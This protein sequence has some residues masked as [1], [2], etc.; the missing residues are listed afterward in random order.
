[1]SMNIDRVI[2][3]GNLTHD[4]EIRFTPKG[5]HVASLAL[6]ISRRWKSP[7]GEHLEAK[8]FFDVTLY[9]RLAE[10]CGKSLAKGSPVMIEGR[11]EMQMWEDKA[12]GQKRSKLVIIGEYVHFPTGGRKEVA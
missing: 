11:H 4:P 3:A 12:T 9:G 8:V 6:A 5:T 10:A 2:I 1:M 7:D